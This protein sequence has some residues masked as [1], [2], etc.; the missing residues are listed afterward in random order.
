MKKTQTSVVTTTSKQQRFL[1]WS[2]DVLVYIVVLNLFVEFVDA[3]VI[4]SFWISILT[5]VLLQAL[6][7]IVVG[8]EHNVGAF[9]EQMGRT[10]SRIAEIVA[11]FLILF[12]SKLLI[13]EIVN[14][15]FGDQVELGHFIDVLVLIIAMMAARAIM[16]RIYMGLGKDG[17]TA[18]TI[19]RIWK[20]EVSLD[21]SDEYLEQMRTVAIPDY[22]STD[23]NQ[24][25]FALRRDLDDRAEFVMLTFWESRE[26][27]MDFAG[28]D[29]SV[30]KYY[31]FDADVLFE[32]IPHVEH[33][34]VYDN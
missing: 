32:M 7:S 10:W 14:F 31:D 20:G 1:S 9:F 24:G 23:G 17:L 8:L 26:A 11:K 22:R 19:A 34:D 30:A 15:V 2:A 4:E 33:F 16:Q 25:A 28:E 6:L 3:I 29:I 18:S 21:K 5:A 27:I 12:T 13:L